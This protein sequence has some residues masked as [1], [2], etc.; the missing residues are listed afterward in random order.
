M[1]FLGLI[2]DT[3]GLLREEA[4]NALAGAAFILHAGDVGG[5]GI[6]ERLERLAPVTAVK[7]NIDKGAWATA[8]PK[9]AVAQFSAA[10]IYVLHDLHELDLD[11]GA[12]GFNLVV[13]G[14]SHKPEHF[15]RAGVL[16]VNPGSAGPRRFRL[17]ITVVR[18]DVWKSPWQVTYIDLSSQTTSDYP[19]HG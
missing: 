15:E 18:L 7:G 9:T 10:S 19:P 1:A 17:P 13:S 3:H 6:L 11:P 12:A 5:S 2:S 16:Y 4:I 8:L 14:H